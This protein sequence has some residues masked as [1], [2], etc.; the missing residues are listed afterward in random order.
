MILKR[1]G[2]VLLCYLCGCGRLGFEAM[3]PFEGACRSDQ[4]CPDGRCDLSQDPP[5]CVTLDGCGNGTVDTGEACD[6]GNQTDGDGC[7]SSCALEAN[8][9]CTNDSDCASGQCNTTTGQCVV[10]QSC[11]G[12]EINGTCFD[13][14]EVNPTNA[15]LFC[16]PSLA[17]DSW[18]SAS[19]GTTCSGGGTCDGNGVCNALS[20][21][22]LANGFL[23]DNDVLGS[24]IAISQDLMVVGAPSQDFYPNSGKAFIYQQLANETWSMLDADPLSGGMQYLVAS[25]STIGNLFGG[26][27]SISGDDIAVGAYRASTSQGPNRGAVYMFG[28]DVDG[29]WSETVKLESPRASTSPYDDFGRKII[30]DGDRLFVGESWPIGY[31]H[32]YERTAGTWTFK[33]SLQAS[34][35]QNNDRFAFAFAVEGNTLIIGAPGFSNG[36]DR[37]IVYRYSY[38]NGSWGSEQELDRGDQDGD[39]FGVAVALEGDLAVIG[40][41]ETDDGYTY[42]GPGYVR[43]YRLG[44]TATEL[45]TLT[46]PDQSNLGEGFGLS[47]DIR[48]GLILIG[49]PFDETTGYQRAG[50]AFLFQPLSSTSYALSHVFVSPNTGPDDRF[51]ETCSFATGQSLFC[52]C[53]YEF[54]TGQNEGR[55]YRFD[56]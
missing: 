35:A 9:V 4:D 28:R 21:S 56:Y 8:Q 37:G 29:V 27:V 5:I 39:I 11:Q 51:A 45:A 32:Y 3:P 52:A 30:V 22:F 47:V 49:S 53:P 16:D 38:V 55:V 31:L 42:V 18:Q 54:I 34:N 20:T 15:C 40:A 7:D 17:S 14:S 2:L 19:A 13:T 23:G 50:A 43:L 44:T 25:D 41:A 36:S 46:K 10:S 6:D 12:C 48:N 26:S 33:Q 1:L 24:A